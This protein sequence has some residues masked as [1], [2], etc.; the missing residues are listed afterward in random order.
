MAFKFS[1][2]PYINSKQQTLQ[3]FLKEHDSKLDNLIK[4][5]NLFQNVKQTKTTEH[6]RV[7]STHMYISCTDK[8]IIIKMTLTAC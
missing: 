2:Y 5:P 1:F 8:D 4:N 7:L 3:G 6:C